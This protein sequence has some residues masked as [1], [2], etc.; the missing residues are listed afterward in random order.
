LA[1]RSA[2][3]ARNT[4]SLIQQSVESANSGVEI[5]NEVAAVL[6]DI[7]RGS[8]KVNGLISEIAAASSEQATGIEQVNTAVAQM[9]K[10]TQESAANAEESAAAA[11]EL[12]SQSEQVRSIVDQLQRILGVN[13]GGATSPAKSSSSKLSIFKLPKRKSTSDAVSFDMPSK[14]SAPSMA[15]APSKPINARPDNAAD[16]IPFDD[17]FSDFDTKAA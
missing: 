8:E 15:P 4:S 10:V 3:A 12:A 9:D 1:M 5:S 17:D 7:T 11:E 2:E 14:S 13:A 6:E 16:M